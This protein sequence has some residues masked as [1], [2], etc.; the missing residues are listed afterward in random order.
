MSPG[1]GPA[2]KQYQADVAEFFTSIGIPATTDVLLA[3]VRGTHAIDVVARPTVAGRELLWI[4]ECK[5]W[6]RPVPKEKILTLHAIAQDVGADGA[7]VMAEAGYQSGALQCARATNLMLTSLKDLCETAR[8]DV[9]I[10]GLR[11][12]LGRSRGLEKRYWAIPKSVRILGGLRRLVGVAGPPSIRERIA[13]VQAGCIELIVSGVVPLADEGPRDLVG[14]H[15]M[16]CAEL[17]DCERLIADVEERWGAG[18]PS[19]AGPAPVDP[20]HAKCVRRVEEMIDMGSD[21]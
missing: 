17:D 21:D 3:G 1:D 20:E 11:E 16:L 9:A 14:W 6:K 18:D 8:V 19:L 13:A 4:V 5:F 15:S 12:L 7:Y 2:W 10:R